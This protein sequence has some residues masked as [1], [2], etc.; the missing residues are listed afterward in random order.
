M[1]S[2]SP[3][4]S[5]SSWFLAP[6]LGRE[7]RWRGEFIVTRDMS[8]REIRVTWVVMGVRAGQWPMHMPRIALSTGS[9]AGIGAYLGSTSEKL[10]YI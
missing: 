1:M 2:A 7:G 3:S 6:G 5:L 8:V 4:K 9:S 10:R